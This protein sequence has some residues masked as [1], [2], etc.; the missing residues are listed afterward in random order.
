[1]A[2]WF[3]EQLAGDIPRRA[4]P[5][6]IAQRARAIMLHIITQRLFCDRSKTRVALQW[7]PLLEDFD[8]CRQ[9]S[10]G[11]AVLAF[12]YTELTRVALVQQRSVGGCM[13]LLQ[14]WT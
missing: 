2:T 1:M 9:Y 7:L 3:R 4:S 8:S 14:V 12:T 11:S 10:W 5:L 13:T 6:Q